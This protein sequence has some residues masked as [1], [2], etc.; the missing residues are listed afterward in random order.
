MSLQK[1]IDTKDV[2][3]VRKG[4]V[5]YKEDDSVVKLHDESY[6]KAQVLNE[7]LNHARAEESGLAIPEL[8]EIVN[9]DGFWG[10]RS[11]Y[12][13]GKTLNEKMLEDPENMD[14][15]LD[16]LIKI[17]TTVLEKESDVLNDLH[18][19]FADR[20]KKTKYNASIR[21]ELSARLSRMTKDNKICHGDLIPSNII[22]HPSGTDYI[23]DW[24]HATRGNAEADAATTYL[25]LVLRGDLELADKYLHRYCELTDTAVQEVQAWTSL[26][27]AVQSLNNVD[28]QSKLLKRWVNVVEFD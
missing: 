10:I 26:V 17:Q 21:Y 19:K 9:Y 16:R 7:A 2:I 4:K 11:K 22:L 3:T 15:Y 1:Y 23:L 13:E 6:T 25:H 28:G 18:V 12:I 8:L 24:S 20:I 27:A 5:I 14:E